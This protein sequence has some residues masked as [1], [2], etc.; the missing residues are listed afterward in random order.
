MIDAE[1]ALVASEGG[2][3]LRLCGR[4][5]L[6]G[7]EVD[8]GVAVQDPIRDEALKLLP[9]ERQIPLAEVVRLADPVQCAQPLAVLT[10][11]YRT[12]MARA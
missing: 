3:D 4:T 6:V 7:G 1:V 5:A 2:P 10:P 11:G 12:S 8:V 9:V